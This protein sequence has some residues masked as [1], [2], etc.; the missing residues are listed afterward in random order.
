MA[1][2]EF[3]RD[4]IAKSLLALA[5]LREKKTGVGPHTNSK[6]SSAEFPEN[7]LFTSELAKIDLISQGRTVQN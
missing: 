4:G 2:A 6:N 3:S 7:P 1:L 5:A